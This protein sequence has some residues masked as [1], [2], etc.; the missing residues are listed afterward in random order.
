MCT[1]SN[2]LVRRR[3]SLPVCGVPRRTP[4]PGNIDGLVP[5]GTWLLSV[6]PEWVRGGQRG[7]SVWHK[8]C[9]V[10]SFHPVLMLR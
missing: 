10:V 7:T 1:K 2:E 9:R 5:F 8:A 4:G 6:K 3:C